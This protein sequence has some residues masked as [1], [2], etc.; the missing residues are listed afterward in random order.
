MRSK[1]EMSSQPMKRFVPT[2]EDLVEIARHVLQRPDGAARLARA[3]EGFVL[4]LG[5]WPLS[6]ERVV[7]LEE[8]PAAVARGERVLAVSHD[9]DDDSL[10]ARNA[11]ILAAREEVYESISALYEA[12]DDQNCD[13]EEPIHNWAN[14]TLRMKVQLQGFFWRLDKA[15][16]LV[17]PER[18][19]GLPHDALFDVLLVVEPE[20]L[21][22][23]LQVKSARAHQQ[24][25]M[26]VLGALGSWRLDKLDRHLRLI[27]KEMWS[28][29]TRKPSVDS[30]FTREDRLPP[31]ELADRLI[32]ELFGRS[33]E[34]IR[35]AVRSAGNAAL[36]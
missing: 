5:G 28:R 18:R 6:D 4:G 2:P 26:E 32:A 16:G 33:P 29:R 11:R 35:K 8:A 25:Q 27:A 14:W 12:M 36:S 13:R 15:R 17:P 24:H 1:Q 34:T 19:R 31:A 23:Q 22:A 20:I 21:T 9:P 7:S 3:F 30:P 10:A